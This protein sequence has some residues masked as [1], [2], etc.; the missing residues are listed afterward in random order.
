MPWTRVNSPPAAQPKTPSRPPKT[1]LP[2]NAAAPPAPAVRKDPAGAAV[3]FLPRRTA[4]CLWT[5]SEECRPRTQEPARRSCGSPNQGVGAPKKTR[6]EE[7][8]I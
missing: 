6:P 5:S 7:A 4:L 1:A 3:A 8:R 2:S